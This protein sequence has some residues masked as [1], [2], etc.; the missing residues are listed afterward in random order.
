MFASPSIIRKH[1]KKIK[2]NN[3]NNIIIIYNFFNIEKKWQT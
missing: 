3:N 1:R 2:Y